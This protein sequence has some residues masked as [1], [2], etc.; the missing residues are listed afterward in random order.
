MNRSVAQMLSLLANERHGDW[1]VLLPH[2]ESVW[3]SSFGSATLALNGTVCARGVLCINPS[4]KSSVEGR[5]ETRVLNAISSNIVSW[6]GSVV[7]WRTSLF[8]SIILSTRP[9]LRLPIR[10]RATHLREGGIHNQKLDTR[11]WQFDSRTTVWC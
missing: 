9:A 5:V 6:P 4:L 1:D 7:D 8:E 10:V 2:I 11:A 3:N